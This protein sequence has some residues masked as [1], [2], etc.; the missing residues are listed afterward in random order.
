MIILKCVR[1]DSGDRASAAPGGEG[2]GTEGGRCAATQ[3]GK[4]AP[5]LDLHLSFCPFEHT[6]A[7]RVGRWACF[8]L[9]IETIT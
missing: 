6:F 4:S 5:A 2:G 3:T 8:P 7:P 9:P 1:R